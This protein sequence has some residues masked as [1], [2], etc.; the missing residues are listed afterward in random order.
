MIFLDMEPVQIVE[1]EGLKRFTAALDPSYKLPSRTTVSRMM[2]PQ[3]YNNCKQPATNYNTNK[4][5]NL[6]FISINL[7]LRSM[8]LDC[9]KL[10]DRHILQ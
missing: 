4:M 2:M 9:C 3:F 7:E 1:R 5:L 8:I 10:Y 6:L